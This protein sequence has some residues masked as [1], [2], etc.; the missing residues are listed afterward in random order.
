MEKYK[1]E[2]FVVIRQRAVLSIDEGEALLFLEDRR[3]LRGKCS[4]E[5]S[6]V[7]ISLLIDSP[8]L[9][10]ALGEAH[11]ILHSILK[12]KLFLKNSGEVILKRGQFVP[13]DSGAKRC[14]LKN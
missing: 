10:E 5:N 3:E 11:R 1:C 4:V 8:S 7:F 9:G 12:V 2:I 6:E 13:E 14:I